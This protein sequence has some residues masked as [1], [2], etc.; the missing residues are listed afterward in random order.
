MR[1]LCMRVCVVENLPFDKFAHLRIFIKN[2][3]V[4][5]CVSECA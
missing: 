3:F 2:I 4:C 1:M 5:V